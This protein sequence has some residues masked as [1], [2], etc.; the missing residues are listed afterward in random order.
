MHCIYVSGSYMHNNDRPRGARTQATA[1]ASTS[2]GRQ[3]QARSRQAPV[4]LTTIIE[5]IL[6]FLYLNY[7]HW[8]CIKL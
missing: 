8:M 1:G 6:F 4:H 5:F 3:P 2:R 7:D